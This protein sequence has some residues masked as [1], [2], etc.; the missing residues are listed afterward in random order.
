MFLVDWEYNSS[1]RDFSPVW[2]PESAHLSRPP[3]SISIA[4]SD[5]D[6]NGKD[7]I[8]VG[9]DF[10]INIYE[11]TGDNTYA[12]KQIITSSA[13]YPYYSPRQLVNLPDNY[14]PGPV[15]TYE[16]WLRSSA[17]TSSC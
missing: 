15:N 13:I 8:I 10:G 14:A 6:R 16:G 12:T 5:Q 17:P 3:S 7:E 4:I 9:D 11:N 2:S 1:I